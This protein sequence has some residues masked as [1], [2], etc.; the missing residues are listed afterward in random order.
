M[1]PEPTPQ[2]PQPSFVPPGKEYMTIG[3]TPEAF[4]HGTLMREFTPYSV[5]LSRIREDK[6]DAFSPLGTGV[7]VKKGNRF[8]ILTAHHCLH[9]C[10]PQVHLGIAGGDRLSLILCN[11]RGFKLE[12][13]E[14]QEH[15][16][17]T[18][19]TDEFGPDLTFIEV[20][21]LQ[22]LSSLKAIGLF[23]SLDRPPDEVLATFGTAL[24][25]IANLGYPEFDYKTVIDGNNIHHA[26]RHMTYYNAIQVG[27]VFERDGWDYLD[28]TIR[29]PGSDLP[30]SFAGLSGGPVW[31]MEVRKHKSDGHLSI[32]K[33][34]LIG[35]T[36]YQ[37]ERQDDVRRLRSHFINSIYDLAWRGLS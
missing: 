4:V 31:G 10:N 24:T 11:G 29:Y 30:P 32:E 17:A 14:V 22:R 36:F 9:A 20:L 7:L 23:W 21:A 28:T 34:A 15:V 37:T 35:I 26:V 6:A 5:A 3:D 2:N 13:Q 8:G 19:Q 18:P 25:P 12:S 1:T 16:L 33:S 27:D